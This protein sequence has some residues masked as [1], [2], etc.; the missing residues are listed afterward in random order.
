MFLGSAYCHAGMYEEA[1]PA[2]KK[3][4]RVKPDNLF[5]HFGLAATY[6]LLGS[7]E[8]ARAEAAEVLRIHPKF[9]VQHWAKTMPYKNEADRE[10]TINALRKAGLK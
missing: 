6:S 9:S 4:L 5:A 2:Y 7:E 8:E 10:L 3:A 1:V